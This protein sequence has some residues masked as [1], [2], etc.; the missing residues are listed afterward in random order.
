ME[1]T[2]NSIRKQL[3]SEIE[4]IVV[5]A[6]SSD[7]SQELIESN[8]EIIDQKIIGKDK[9]IYDGMNKGLSIAQGEYC[10]FINSGDELLCPNL[11]ELLVQNEAFD[12]IYGD[13]EIH[14]QNGFERIAKAE[15]QENLWKSLPFVHQ[16]VAVK[17]NVLKS[18]PFDLN[19]RFCSDYELFCRLE[20]KGH[21]F[22]RIENIIAR[23]EA[24]GVSDEK[25]DEAT[26]EVF[27]I[28]NKYRNLT[29]EQK[30][31]FENE[32]KRGRRIQKV[33]KW[34]P[35]SLLKFALKMKYRK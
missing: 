24:G 20:S 7:G 10:I 26:K 15:D 2:F 27:E 29:T 23:I 14:Y 32:I 6:D 11:C 1:R 33:K 13:T 19:Y 35:S 31:Y 4:Y 21:S 30:S 12:C 16:S 5:D 25:R 28:S 22:L 3:N 17:T 18:N 9:G 8:S 34:I